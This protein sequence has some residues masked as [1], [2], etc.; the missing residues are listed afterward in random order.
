VLEADGRSYLIDK[1]GLPYWV[2]GAHAVPEGPVDPVKGPKRHKVA[3]PEALRHGGS[4]FA[5]E[6]FVDHT[7]DEEGV[8]WFLVRWFG[9]GPDDDAWQP[10]GRLP[11]AAV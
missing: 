2:S 1:F 11:V 9:Y 3:V 4:E 10:S 5:F 6:M 7:W 8:L